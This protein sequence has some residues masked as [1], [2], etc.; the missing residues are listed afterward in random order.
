MQVDKTLAV[1]LQQKE[2]RVDHIDALEG[3]SKALL[4]AHPGA[5]V[6]AVYG[7]MGVGKT[8]FIKALC[9]TLGVSD[10]VSS[11]SFPIVNHY[12][13][14]KGESL[15]HFDFY[16][17]KALEEVYDLGYEDYFYSG[18]HCFIEWPEKV[19]TLLPED[20]VRVFM[21]EDHGVRII[22]F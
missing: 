22:R 19:E 4:A 2:Y 6:F 11:P 5:R 16:R 17:I 15:Y 1:I 10:M 9:K 8:V 18:N 12:V 21:E 20:T 7:T 3:A 14:E 13:S